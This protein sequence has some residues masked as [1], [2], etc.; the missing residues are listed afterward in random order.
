MPLGD[1][2]FWLTN[3]KRC[4]A[5]RAQNKIVVQWIWKRGTGGGE[6]GGGGGVGGGGTLA[7][8]FQWSFFGFLSAWL[9]EWDEPTDDEVVTNTETFCHPE[10]THVRYK[11][12]EVKIMWDSTLLN[13]IWKKP[14]SEFTA[15][16]Q[17]FLSN[18]HFSPGGHHCCGC[19]DGNGS[20]WKQRW[21]MHITSRFYT[22]AML[23][24]GISNWFKPSSSE[25]IMIFLLSDDLLVR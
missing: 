15:R 20:Y 7:S 14:I 21:Q 25:E 5:R 9:S 17:K 3:R 16:H 2:K 23:Q 13:Y 11:L 24:D 10:W 12:A 22:T 1:E 8:M 6:E 18:S 19:G 4:F